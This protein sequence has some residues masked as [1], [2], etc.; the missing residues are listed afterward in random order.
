M[1]HV[2]NLENNETDFTD[3]FQRNYYLES[4]NFDII[5][6]VDTQ[7]TAGGRTEPQH[8]ATIT[9]LTEFGVSFEIRHL[10]V[11]D[12]A[13]IARCRRNKNNELILPFIVER[14]RIDDL[15]ASITDG[16]FS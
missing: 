9:G 6:L 12:F 15:S 3:D 8:D 2:Y 14:K 7:E 13:W 5:L 16:R 1:N 10:K 11:G 4:S